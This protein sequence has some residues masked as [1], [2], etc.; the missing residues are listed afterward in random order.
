MSAVGDVYGEKS[1]KTAIRARIHV[2]QSQKRAI[3]LKKIAKRI[4]IQYTYLSKA[5]ND[6]RAHLSEDRLFRLCRLLELGLEETDFVLLLREYETAEDPEWREHLFSRVERLRRARTLEAD[7]Q[8]FHTAKLDREMDYLFDPLAKVVLI[9]LFIPEYLKNPRLLC[10]QLGITPARL[11]LVL[12][13]LADVGHIELDESGTGVRKLLRSHIHYG[14]DHP[15]MRVH[16]SLLKTMIHSQLLRVPEEDKHSLLVTL[17]LD[18]AGFEAA[19]EE[20]QK[21]LKAL[22]GIAKR[23]KDEGAYQLSFDLFRWV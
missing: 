20:F 9:S 19:K 4:R 13:R 6:P 17:T 23:S 12:Q 16:Q 18:R 5:L 11:R 8:E 14:R 22:E 1:Y 10:P 7:V 21:Y 2:L 15:L 3:T